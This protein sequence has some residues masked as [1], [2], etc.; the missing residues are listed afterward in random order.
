MFGNI[1]IIDVH[2]VHC[3]HVHVAVVFGMLLFLNFCIL[4]IVNTYTK[5]TYVTGSSFIPLI[6]LVIYTQ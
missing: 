4:Y 5:P 6:F 3:N 2:L 1:S